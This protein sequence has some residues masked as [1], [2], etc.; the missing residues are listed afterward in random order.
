MKNAL[1]SK[2]KMKMRV[3]RTLLWRRRLRRLQNP[4]KKK[5]RKPLSEGQ[6]KLLL[7]FLQIPVQ[8][9]I[10]IAKIL[11]PRIKKANWTSCEVS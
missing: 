10:L 11:I 4:P 3:Y 9:L 1:F 8:I 2:I 6:M 5:E 7:A